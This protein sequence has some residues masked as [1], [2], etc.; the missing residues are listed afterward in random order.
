MTTPL[1]KQRLEEAQN[2][3]K[4]LYFD[5][6]NYK[7]ACGWFQLIT[8]TDWHR[9]QEIKEAKY[10]GT[11]LENLP[12]YYFLGIPFNKLFRFEY[13]CRNCH[14]MALALSMCFDEFEIVT[15]NLKNYWD[16][17]YSQTYSKIG[18]F[19]HTF[20]VVTIAD[21]KM[22]IDTTWGLITDLETYDYI[23]DLQDIKTISSNEIKE[24]DVYKFMQ[25]NKYLKG[26]SFESERIKDEEYQ[27][28][29]KMIYRHMDLCKNYKNEN[30]PH[31]EDFLN[32][33]IYKTSNISTVDHW[34]MNQEFEYRRVFTYPK[35][36]MHSL[37][38]DEF[39]YNLRSSE[40]ETNKRNQE[41]VE[42]YHKPKQ[43]EQSQ[44]KLSFWKKL[45]SK[46]KISKN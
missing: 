7:L 17:Y 28:Y 9:P 3:D 33:C 34:R 24:T 19:E 37:E 41:I 32:R 27:N 36:K 30:N 39:D 25:E 21:K 46:N 8:R 26:P 13:S 16:Y 12:K 20:L 40:E 14:S 22:V 18:K 10:D 5:Y 44:I 6:I 45:F 15:A 31:L 38:D 42:S 2:N 29:E 43:E 11:F 1:Y 23:F 4:V 35:V